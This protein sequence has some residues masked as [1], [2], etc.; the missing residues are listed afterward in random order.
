MQAL[1]SVQLT[2]TNR[3]W[4][5]IAYFFT[6]IRIFNSRIVVPVNLLYVVFREWPENLE[7]FFINFLHVKTVH[8]QFGGNTAVVRPVPIPNT[9][10]KH[11]KAD[12][13]GCIASARVGSRQSFKKSPVIRSPGIFLLFNSQFI[14]RK[15]HQSTCR[16]WESMNPKNPVC[17]FHHS[18]LAR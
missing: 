17:Y 16:K 12:G 18:S 9:A 6:E 4:G 14:F 2:D 11:C 10:V 7:L 13:S 3:S 15:F 5:L 1:R 8:T